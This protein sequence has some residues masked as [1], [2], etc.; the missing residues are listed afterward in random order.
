M[1]V[2]KEEQVRE[3]LRDV[4]ELVASELSQ[5]KGYNITTKPFPDFNEFSLDKK[6]YS[7]GSR[8]TADDIKAKIRWHAIE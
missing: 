3:K 8:L 1:V 4:T 5:A 6:S 2:A 7:L